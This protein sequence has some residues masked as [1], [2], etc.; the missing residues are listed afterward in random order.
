[1]F[2]FTAAANDTFRRADPV[3]DLDREPYVPAPIGPSVIL[4]AYNVYTFA[5]SGVVRLTLLSQVTHS[6]CCQSLFSIPGTGNGSVEPPCKSCAE[7]PNVSYTGR[8]G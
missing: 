3:A 6:S 5:N 7:S 1:M 4:N 2:S 8:A